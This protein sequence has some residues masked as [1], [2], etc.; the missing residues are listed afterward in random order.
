MSN[1]NPPQIAY[2]L[3]PL[4]SYI[5][6]CL[7]PPVY[8]ALLTL[9]THGLAFLSALISL[10]TALITSRPSDW[11]VQKILPPIITLLAAYLALSSAVRTATWFVRMTTWI[12]K[13]GIITAAV[14][15]ATAWVFASGGVVPSLT[16][17]AL[18]MLNGQGQDAAGGPRG[19]RQHGRTRPQAWESFD[20]HWEWQF[21]EQQWNTADATSPSQHV[22]QFIAD[23]LQRARDGGL[24]SIA[25]GALQSFSDPGSPAREGGDSHD[26]SVNSDGERSAPSGQ[27]Y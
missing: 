14:S 17:L 26:D 16:G 2:I 10:G 18:N 19:S 25:R 24:W 8:H 22:Q 13:W 21:E 1:A 20:Q 12:I 9:I 11:D 7:P 3:E 15:A 5:S 6:S 27:S 23:A 4:L